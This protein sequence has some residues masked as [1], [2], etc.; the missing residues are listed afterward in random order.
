MTQTFLSEFEPDLSALTPAEREAYEAIRCG[1]M[2]VREFARNTGRSPGT[3]G[4]LL[5]RAESK[6]DGSR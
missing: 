1:R 5:R 4:N 2:G 6:M 3:V